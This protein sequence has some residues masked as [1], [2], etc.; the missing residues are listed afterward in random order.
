MLRTPNQVSN[1]S[2][3]RGH[4]REGLRARL[5][6]VAAGSMAIKIIYVPLQLAVGVVLARLLG[7]SDFGTYS[8]VLAM[9][10][11]L[12]IPAQLGIPAFLTRMVA[13]YES[14]GEYRLLRGLL[15][16]SSR[17]VVIA[18][19]CVAGLTFG[20]VSA[21]GLLP[22]GVPGGSF[23]AGLVLVVLLGL[24]T[25]NSGALSG[26]GQVWAAQVTGEI[27]RPIALLLGLLITATVVRGGLTSTGAVTANVAAT[28]IALIVGVLFLWG[29]SRSLLQGHTPTYRTGEWIRGALPFMLLA[30]TQ[31]V[32]YYAD[33]LM[34]GYMS[35][36]DKVG[37]YRVAV[38]V[39]DGLGMSL[40]AITMAIRPTLAG[41]HDADDW[42]RIQRMLVGGHRAGVA[43]VLPLAVLLAVFSEPFLGLVFGQEYVPAG[44]ALVILVLGKALYATVCFGGV[45]LSMFGKA[46]VASAVTIMSAVLNV[47]MNA[48]LIPKIGIEGAATA[49][50]VSEFVL[51]LACILWIRRLYGYDVSVLGIHGG[52]QIPW[53]RASE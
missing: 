12:V 3:L 28:A 53:K 27:V 40:M 32:N 2:K 5:I 18:S 30:G 17:V 11:L 8:F 29:Q 25:A 22:D 14:R 21:L 42:P 33:L 36:P 10:Q 15:S 51:S 31:A 44:P 1:G 7:P 26:L 9:A 23:L 20:V 49:T 16:R 24:Q 4:L 47:A 6:K 19:G 46:S 41:L 48:V 52:G 37:L 34:L 13:V 50:L 43:I 39:A 38:Q 45:A 35:T